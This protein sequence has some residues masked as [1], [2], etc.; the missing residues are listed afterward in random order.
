METGHLVTSGQAGRQSEQSLG[1]QRVSFPLHWSLYQTCC[2][3]DHSHRSFNL[4]TPTLTIKAASLST[5]A[6]TLVLA[7]LSIY[8]CCLQWM[9][10]TVVGWQPFERGKEKKLNVIM[11]FTPSSSSLG[12]ADRQGCRRGWGGPVCLR[13]AKWECALSIHCW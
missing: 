13:N 11:L 10:L 8:P 7:K 6:Q 2:A 1:W 3:L 4:H 5:A 12:G 9:G